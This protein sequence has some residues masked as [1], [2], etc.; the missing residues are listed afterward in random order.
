MPAINL[1][2]H[3][4]GTTIQLDEPFALPVNAPLIVTVLE[5]DTDQAQ[6]HSMASAALERAYGPNEPEYTDADLQP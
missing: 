6:W 1:R 2:A 4:D 3:F 5:P